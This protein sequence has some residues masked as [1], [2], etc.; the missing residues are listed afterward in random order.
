ME[1][2]HE[3]KHFIN[4]LEAT[5]PVDEWKID[6]VHLWPFMRVK[7]FFALLAQS[8]KSHNEQRVKATPVKDSA[9]A[10][11]LQS[12]INRIKQSNKYLRFEAKQHLRKLPNTDYL[13]ATSATH[14]TEFQN[15]SFN[16][17]ADPLLDQLFTGL[18]LETSPNH[19]YNREKVNRPKQV[20]YF[21][22]YFNAVLKSEERKERI[23]Q[24]KKVELDQYAQFL[25]E[26]ETVLKVDLGS[27]GITEEALVKT[28]D[29]FHDFAETYELILDRVKPKV[30]LTVCFYSF[31]VMV[32]NYVAKKKGLKTIEIQH[33]P[34]S[35]VH[36]GYAAWNKV[37]DEGFNTL[38]QY[39]WNWD[40]YSY[41]VISAWTDQQSHHHCFVAGNPWMQY[42]N[43]SVGH[44]DIVLYSLQNLT[45]EH[46]FP[47][48]LVETIKQSTHEWWIR[49]HPRQLEY[50]DDVQQFF[51]NKNITDKVNIDEATTLPLPVVLSRTIV[52][53]T[54]FSGCTLEAADLGIPSVVIDIRGK[55]AFEALIEE[56]KVVYCEEPLQFSQELNKLSNTDAVVTEVEK[57]DWKKT[58]EELDD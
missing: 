39:F 20:R 38:P 57:Y 37:P 43:K 12:K 47:P 35:D 36:M 49:L 50:L 13:I 4:Q 44:R 40:K 21:Y 51:K 22:D 10:G 9:H 15:K 58:I 56:G 42:L 45:F 14:R 53:V 54:N 31:S 6:G 33:G 24:E 34:Q 52:H 17:F 8:E 3:I 19:F 29:R 26:V 18:N 1:T 2:R 23:Q 48:Y 41:K 28:M 55:D 32:L 27:V 46:L 30:V 16:K 5:K 11:F 7:L 25:E